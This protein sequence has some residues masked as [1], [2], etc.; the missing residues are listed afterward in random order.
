MKNKNTEIFSGKAELYGKNRPAYPKEI[1]YFIS[2]FIKGADVVADIGAGTGIFTEMLCHLGCNLIAVE[3]N[4]DMLMR[5]SENLRD[6]DN[7]TLVKSTAEETLLADKSVDLVTAA[8]SFHW[9]EPEK[10]R[11]ECKRILRV[12]GRVMLM[13]N[14][15]DY[16][17]D[18]IK[19]RNEIAAKYCAE[20]AKREKQPSPLKGNSDD[21][22]TFFG[23]ENEYESYLLRNDLEFD[24]DGY[25]GYELSHSYAPKEGDKNFK[26][27]TAA[28]KS[29]FDS[30]SEGGKIVIPNVTECYFGTVL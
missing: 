1:V 8:Q 6:Y 20:F 12:N 22:I 24:C 16:S 14:T 23:G 11:N 29:F 18:I 19:E 4:T 25:V 21:I 3:P 9:F 7:L 13:W 17:T 27:Y 10:F 28:L 26:A 5:A 15:A 30:Y 2:T